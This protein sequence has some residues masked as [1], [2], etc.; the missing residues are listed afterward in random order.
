[1]RIGNT[2]LGSWEDDVMSDPFSRLIWKF[3]LIVVPTEICL[4]VWYW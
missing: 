2:E 1:M 3:N 4:Y